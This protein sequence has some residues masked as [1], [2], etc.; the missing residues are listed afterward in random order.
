MPLQQLARHVP[1]SANLRIP[2]RKDSRPFFALRAAGGV[3]TAGESMFYHRVANDEADVPRQR[4][5]FERPRTAGQQ[6]CKYPLSPAGD[7]IVHDPYSC[8]DK[9]IL[10][11]LPKVGDLKQGQSS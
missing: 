9:S 5:P 3:A 1:E 7:K 2:T 4:H 8:A 10:R 11:P 6:K